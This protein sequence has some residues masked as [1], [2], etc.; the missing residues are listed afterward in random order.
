MADKDNQWYNSSDDKKSGKARKRPQRQQGQRP[1]GQRPQGAAQGQRPQGQPGQRPQGQQAPAQGQ[2]N[3]PQ[4]GRP[5]GTNPQGRP[6]GKRPQGKRPQ[7]QRAH[8]QK[9]HGQRQQTEDKHGARPLNR[10]E[11]RE[12]HEEMSKQYGFTK[13]SEPAVVEAELEKDNI[14]ETAENTAPKETK[15]KKVKEP[16]RK[17]G[18]LDSKIKAERKAVRN[19]ILGA[20]AASAGL[21]VLAFV[22][23]H[24][25]S[26]VAE[27]P[28][29][30]FVTDG[31]IEHTIGA[32]ALIIREETTVLSGTEGELVTSVTEGSRVAAA[33][34]LAM[35]VPPDKE[36]TVTDLRNVQSQISD[37]QQELIESG[38]VDA[39]KNVYNNYNKNLEPIINSIRADSSTGKLQSLA[40]YTSSISVLLDERET[41]LSEIDFNDERLNTL[42]NDER[43][44]QSSLQRSSSIVK[45]PKPGIVSFRLDGQE[46]TLTFDYVMSADRGELRRTINSSVGAIPANFTVKPQ[47]NVLRI[48]QNEKQLF[49]VYLGR[50]DAAATDFAVGTKHDIN[51]AAE[52]LVVEN[53]EVVRCDSDDSGMLIIF[54]TTRFV[55]NLLDLR[56]CDIEIV[57]TKTKGLRLNMANLVNRDLASSDSTGFS[58][59]FPADSGVSEA[60]F[61]TGALFNISVFP[62]NRD[63]KDPPETMPDSFTV[64][65]CEVLHAEKLEDGGVIVGFATRNEYNQILKVADY[66]GGYYKVVFIDSTSGLGTEVY[67]ITTT[68]YKGIA[69]IYVNS[70]GFVEEHRV[71]VTDYDREFA[72]V[73][74]AGSSKIP[75]HDTVIITNPESC[76]PG[77]KVG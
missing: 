31:S 8:A 34:N 9:D 18:S 7:D 59:Y 15:Q 55:E 35:V 75:N 62:D 56:T 47:T 46:D 48:V 41:A 26:Y 14:A 13:E 20:L 25:V 76:E 60:S 19:G 38:N 68:Q 44:Y 29:F 69:S 72:I 30:S 42:R 63:R 28:K 22:F 51:I 50:R 4:G 57:I 43:M 37:V 52:G 61:A 17:K 10:R 27:K 74:P 71:L 73:L 21:L 36:S 5:Q 24:F 66:N 54:S 32:K 40:T 45:S 6:Q 39:A 11:Q 12:Q 70:Q 16:K 2:A 53:A 64:A 23:V 77:G 33:Q 1:N 58:V 67:K 49:A 65:G 3:R